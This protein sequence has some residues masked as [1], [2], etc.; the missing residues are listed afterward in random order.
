MVFS[1]LR[2]A[3]LIVAFPYGVLSD[4]YAKLTIPISLFPFHHSQFAIS[5]SPFIFYWCMST[6][7]RN[8]DEMNP[9]LSNVLN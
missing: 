2:Y 5:N 9:I 3:G 6:T 7:S 4:R 8:S 1:V